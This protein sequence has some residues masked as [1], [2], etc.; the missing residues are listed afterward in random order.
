MQPHPEKGIAHLL[1]AM[2]AG[3]ILSVIISCAENDTE[4][5]LRR[6]YKAVSS[7]NNN[8]FI[9]SVVVW[10]AP[11]CPGALVESTRSFTNCHVVESNG[12]FLGSLP[13]SLAVISKESGCNASYLLLCSSGVVLKDNCFSF[14]KETVLSEY[15]DDVV[16]TAFGIRLFPHM[17]ADDPCRSLKEGT[18]WKIYDHT[19]TDR[20]VHIFSTEFC[21]LSMDLLRKISSHSDS[22]FSELDHLWCSFVLGHFLQYS[23]WKIQVDAVADFSNIAW[24]QL[25]PVKKPSLFNE[26]YSYTVQHDWPPLISQPF[27]SIDKMEDVLQNRKTPHQVWQDGFGGVNMAAEP[28]TELDFTA[29][30]AYGVH[31]IRIGA[32]CD[33][34]D[35]VF[36]MDSQALTIEEDKTHFLQVIPRLRSILQKAS[37]NGIK[38]II[39]MTDLPGGMF[40]FHSEE[41]GS[42]PFW[43][44]SCSR[45]RAAKFWGLVAEALADLKSII[46]GYD[47]I[48]EPYTPEDRDVGFFDEMLTARADELNQFYSDVVKEIRA[49]DKDTVVIIKS[50]WFGSPR[51]F[52]ILQP[53]HDPNVVY[54]FHMYAPPYLTLHRQFNMHTLSYPGP[55]P[56]WP[57]CTDPDVETVQITSDYLH[58]MLEKSVHSWQVK[59]GIPSDRILVAEFGICREIPGARQYL[60]DLVALFQHFK[61]S[62][63][64]FSFRD[65]EWDALDYELGPDMDNMLHRSATKLFKAVADH[66][67]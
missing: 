6:T 9:L 17:I 56:C 7:Q 44:S 38:V 25:L 10:C 2:S 49:H 60:E 67:H 21:L 27:H 31:V 28:A 62:W 40:H 1:L 34:K 35:L 42:F 37:E 41:S 48:N 36:L 5:A 30:A 55:V 43:E 11:N 39:T 54:G 26:F 4:E 51:T 33:A 16:L 19:K 15:D 18:H 12:T 65:E 20:A 53:I 13:S 32:V 63:L 64:L 57:Y 22:R 66:F 58:E 61:W 23:I 50:T 47:V 8:P 14:L 52:D 45:I 24:P 3:E 59:H 29:A 46:M